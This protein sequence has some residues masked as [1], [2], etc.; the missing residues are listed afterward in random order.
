LKSCVFVEGFALHF[1]AIDDGDDGGIDRDLLEALCG[2]RRAALAEHDEF[3]ITG[4]DRIDGD[5]GVLPVLEFRGV[6]L[7]DE[8]RAQQEELPADQL[9]V[10][11]GRD[12]L[13][14]DFSEEHR[15]EGG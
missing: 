11:F 1:D 13:S 9:L 14:N 2:T 3:A 5:D 4:A 6:F 8:F 15:R 7:V 10:F 12:D